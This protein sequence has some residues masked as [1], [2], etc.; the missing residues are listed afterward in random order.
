MKYFFAC[1]LSIQSTFLFATNINHKSD[2]DN[3]NNTITTDEIWDDSVIGY[4]F[5]DA[6]YNLVNTRNNDFMIINTYPKGYIINE[7][8]L[9]KNPSDLIKQLSLIGQLDVSNNF[10][11]ENESFRM[12]GI[13]KSED[14]HGVYATSHYENNNSLNYLWSGVVDNHSVILKIITKSSEARYKKSDIINIVKNLN[15][16]VNTVANNPKRKTISPYNYTFYTY[17]KIT[18]NK[19]ATLDSSYRRMNARFYE[20]DLLSMYGIASF[21]YKEKIPNEFLVSLILDNFGYKNSIYRHDIF[22]KKR[23]FYLNIGSYKSDKGNFNSITLITGNTSCQH[24]LTY[25][26]D[27]SEPILQRLLTFVDHFQANTKSSINLSLLDELEKSRYAQLMFELGR[28]YSKLQI[29]SKAIDFYQEAYK[30][31]TKNKYFYELVQSYYD[32]KQYKEGLNL[33]LANETKIPEQTLSIWKAWYLARLNR[34]TESVAVFKTVLAQEFT[35]DEDLFKY[36]D[37]LYLIKDYQSIINEAKKY[38]KYIEDDA[39]LKVQVAKALIKSDTDKAR[40]YIE[41]LLENEVIAN[42]YQFDLYDYLSDIEAYKLIEKSALQRIKQGYESGV[43]YNYLGDAQNNLGKTN[44]AYQSMKKAHEMA[45]NNTIIE[46]YYKSLQNKIGKSDVSVIENKIPVVSIPPEIQNKIKDIKPLNKND[47]YEYL[48]SID[49]YHH[50]INEKNKHTKYG[51]LKIN[52]ESGIAKNKTF[53]FS[54]NQE[55]ENAYLNYLNVLDKKGEIIAKVDP[56]TTYITTDDDGS[57]GDDDKLLNIPIPSLS[58]GV[59]IEYAFT[60][61]DK[62]ISNTQEFIEKFFASS[63]TNQYKAI[64]I[65]GD[66]HN[67]STTKSSAVKQHNL[68]HHIIYWDYENLP[69]YR[70]TPYLPDFEDI[71]PWIKIATTDKSWQNIGINYLK[72]IHSKINTKFTAQEL[73]PFENENSNLKQQAKNIIAIAQKSITYQA[74]EFGDRALI[75]N[76]ARETLTNKYGDCKDHAVLLYDL[77]NSAGIKAQLALVNSSNTISKELP[78]LGQFNHMIVYLPEIDE[79]V[80]VDITDKNSTIDFNNPPENLQGYTTLVLD[81]KNPKLLTVPK[82]TAENN[83]ITI[84]RTIDKN[85]KYYIYHEKSTINGYYASALRRYLK[86]IELDEMESK[87]ISWVDSYYNDLIIKK[88]K[89]QNLY[90]NAKPLVLEFTFEQDIEFISTKLPVFM[91]FYAMEFTQSPNRQW[92]FENNQ[93]FKISSHTNIKTGTKLKFKRFQA[94]NDTNLLKWN[95]NSG[96]KMIDFQSTVYSNKLPASEYQKL[97]KQ[98]KRSYKI[99]ENLLDD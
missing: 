81:E 76:T 77:L 72:K 23:K 83:K 87:I 6:E 38:S 75:P 2:Y 56:S 7:D 53:Y 10:Y 82:A 92:D 11:S 43:L 22:Y 78:N 8:N 94:Q 1:Y 4:M 27:N 40:T 45:P 3:N 44:I 95:I 21:C 51:K 33:I 29:H 55:Y 25:I 98:S 47:S 68:S 19:A 39:K 16:T 65:E 46:R 62:S 35:Q 30:A 12:G 58:I 20:D 91:E 88:F 89:F 90:D 13:T 42:D 70:K 93:P 80:F 96:K 18:Q 97:V 24:V 61:E 54:F 14:I 48:Y 31:D 36:L 32:L 57:T 71:F 17:P 9:P 79:G 41:K 73:L 63:V 34:P 5:Y 66:I 50:I 69:N 37:Q 52:N 60:V 28:K 64:I 59:I 99:M 26:A 86:N 67:I 85:D 74:I 15:I 84:N 49:A